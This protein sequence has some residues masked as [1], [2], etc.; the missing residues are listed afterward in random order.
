M[1]IQFINTASTKQDIDL[2]TQCINTLITLPNHDP[3][4]TLL[5][6]ELLQL[7]KYPEQNDLAFKHTLRCNYLSMTD[8]NLLKTDPIP[9]ANFFKL[10]NR[11]IQQILTDKEH[12]FYLLNKWLPSNANKNIERMDEIDTLLTILLKAFVN[13]PK[14]YNLILESM[15]TLPF[16]I[17]KTLLEICPPNQNTHGANL[18]EHCI[19][20]MLAVNPNTKKLY[21]LLNDVRT[22]LPHAHQIGNNISHLYTLRCKYLLD[23]SQNLQQWPELTRIQVTQ[24]ISALSK[25]KKYQANGKK[26]AKL[27]FLNDCLLAIASFDATPMHQSTHKDIATQEGCCTCLFGHNRIA[28]LYDQLTNLI[29]ELKPMQSTQMQPINTS[30]GGYQ[31]PKEI[32]ASILLASL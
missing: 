10:P 14:L 27:S 23:Q 4:R 3:R 30:T 28:I 13:Q 22:L 2:I 21:I 20:T 15:Y 24:I 9:L 7:L 32:D 31:T 17:I 5:L 18:I 12:Y 29:P 25:I 8:F 16:N 19:F 1:I 26:T 6:N 11:F